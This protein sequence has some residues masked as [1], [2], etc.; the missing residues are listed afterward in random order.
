MRIL[1][2][3][4]ASL[5][6]AGVLLMTLLAYLCPWVNPVDFRWLTFFGTAFPWLLWANVLLTLL[7]IWRRK[8]LFIYHLG[9]II[10]GWQYVSSFIGFNLNAEKTP[11]KA[12][13]V[14]SHN[15]GGLF[16][17]KKVTEESRAEMAANYAR[18]L[19]ENGDPDILC[20]QETS[21]AFY[22]LLADKMGYAHNFNL[23]KG[24]VILSRF[25]I[26]GG[27]E[28]PFGKTANSTLWVDMRVRGKLLRIY[29]VH[30]QSN[31][32]TND[33]E[34][35]IEAGE[36]N[37]ERTWEEIGRVLNKVGRATRVRAEQAQ[38]LRTHLEQSPHPVLVCGDF[39]DTPNSYVY[40]LVSEG[41]NDPFRLRGRGFATTFSGVLPML[42]IDYLLCEK[43]FEIHDFRTVHGN[44]SD[45]YP[46]V[47]AL[48]L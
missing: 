7:W 47:V 39:N 12:V 20:T 44:F 32:V 5:I 16:R 34:K 45:H 10:L 15:L 23:K 14:A 48:T 40:H 17:G 22:R 38:H 18:F 28:I 4:T 35:V 9:V 41:L 30:L 1:L 37:E 31:K 19:Q 24:T 43:T 33:T 46:V 36:L 26:E 3:S 21:G 8:R 29:N 11:E 6:S 27:G 25:P 42:R 13:I 2:R